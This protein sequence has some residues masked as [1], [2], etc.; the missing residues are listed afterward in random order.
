MNV[1]DG[2]TILNNH[3]FEDTDETQ[4]MA[5]INDT[6]W[7]IDGMEP[8]PYLYKSVNLNFDGTNPYPSNLPTDFAKVKWIT[9]LTT[10][11]S[12]WPERIETIRSRIGKDFAMAGDPNVFYFLGNQLRLWPV[13]PSSTGRFLLDYKAVQPTLTSASAEAAIL[14]P[15]RYHMLWVIGTLARL[16]NMDDDPELASVKK[17]EFDERV[18]KMRM[19]LFAQQEMRSDQI[20]MT[21]PD[22]GYD[23]YWIV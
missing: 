5:F 12:I 4:K 21:D 8:W 9:D 3:G 22:E 2:I 14:M 19:D 1:L 10:G 11:S 16:Y 23:P 13:P 17:A 6:I 18:T 15:A 7:E 20:Y